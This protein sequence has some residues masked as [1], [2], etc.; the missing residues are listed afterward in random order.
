MRSYELS[1]RAAQ[2]VKVVL[3][4]DGGDELFGGY[5]KYKRAAS[6]L[7]RTQWISRVAP[8]LFATSRLGVCAADPLGWRRLRSRAGAPVSLPLAWDELPGMTSSDQWNVRNIGERLE[9]G[10]DPW[11]GYAKA[12]KALTVAMKKM[13]FTPE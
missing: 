2:N 6:P 12:A 9:T 3:T 8:S 1:E 4:G 10:N 11:A 7:A 5:R 13:G